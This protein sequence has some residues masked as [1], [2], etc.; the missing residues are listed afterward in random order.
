MRVSGRYDDPSAPAI[1]GGPSRVAMALAGDE[2]INSN[3]LSCAYQVGKD[4][5]E[6][7]TQ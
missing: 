7:I 5:R 3:S 4:G 1:I 6:P 2:A